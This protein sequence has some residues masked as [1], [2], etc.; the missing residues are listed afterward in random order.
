MWILIHFNLIVIEALDNFFLIPELV[1]QDHEESE[2]ILV[3]FRMHR[4]QNYL[5]KLRDLLIEPHLTYLFDHSI[6]PIL[7]TVCEI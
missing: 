3:F 5:A 1:E 7:S 4:N 2:P 6:N